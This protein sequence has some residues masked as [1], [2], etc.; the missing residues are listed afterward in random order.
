MTA[1]ASDPTPGPLT[2]PPQAEGSVAAANPSTSPSAETGKAVHPED[3]S[4]YQFPPPF[5]LPTL[6][7]AIVCMGAYLGYGAWRSRSVR[8][9]SEACE[10]ALATE[11]WERAEQIGLRWT[12][13][14]PKNSRCLIQ[15]A[16]A[17]KGQQAYDRTAG[18]LLRVP[19]DDPAAL[20]MLSLAA[21]LQFHE[22]VLPFAAEQT[23][24]RM[25]A[26]E[27]RANVPR[28]RLM[29]FYALSLQR[30]KLRAQV[31]DAI[32]AQ[33]ETPDTYVYL[34]LLYEL[35]FSDAFP[36]LSAWLRT[37]P[38]NRI[39]RVA[40]A[41]A[42]LQAPK[43]AGVGL[44]IDRGLRPG[45]PTLM[46]ECLRDYP[47]DLE[48]RAVELERAIEGGR[49]DDVSR[50]LKGAPPG[51]ESD[52]RFWRARGWYLRGSNQLEPAEQACR[53]ALEHYALDWRARHELS[54]VLRR[55]RRES[56][57]EQ[58]AEL[59][60][61]G[62]TL[63]REILSLPNTSE[64]PSRLLQRIGGFTR[65]CGMAEVA[66]AIDFRLGRGGAAQVD[67]PPVSNSA[68]ATPPPQSAP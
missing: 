56:E 19:N 32:R 67:D 41:Y 39:L 2:T 40:Q 47:D 25:V 51:A 53:T 7:I 9:L 17:A 44:Q 30:G 59:A 10:A 46:D 62:K 34:M 57:A 11:D 58:Q 36:K 28:K 66:A 68:I 48:L 38:A 31:L 16:D 13:F 35:R 22:L 61:I 6:A 43:D 15:L 24:L 49:V 60:L 45:D 52:P 29:Y 65:S 63:E 55:Q 27:P 3:S 18:Y 21:D 1:E 54:Q 26:I 8:I 50:I 14:E 23:W 64:L 5:L 4:R 37:D 20:T 33:A 42:L 12:E